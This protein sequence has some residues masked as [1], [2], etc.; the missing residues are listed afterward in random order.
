MNVDAPREIR[1]LLSKWGRSTYDG[2]DNLGHPKKSLVVGD[3]V[4][5]HS[6][7]LHEQYD[8]TDLLRLQEIIEKKLDKDNGEYRAIYSKYRLH[9]NKRES[10]H[11]MGIGQHQY[12]E[13]YLTALAKIV[14]LMEVK[15]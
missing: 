3:Y 14:R 12:Q 7:D 1:V 11:R 13:I 5:P 8:D 9:L 10:A 2:I 15:E 4:S 6:D